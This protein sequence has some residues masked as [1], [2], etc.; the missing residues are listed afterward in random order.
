MPKMVMAPTTVPQLQV[1]CGMWQSARVLECYGV[2]ATA[3]LHPVCLSRAGNGKDSLPLGLAWCWVTFLHEVGVPGA[4][5]LWATRLWTL[6]GSLYGH[7][8]SRLLG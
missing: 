8:C 1:A 2:G 6:L 7:A 5:P 3:I 4:P